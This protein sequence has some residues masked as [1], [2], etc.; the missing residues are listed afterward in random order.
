[1]SFLAQEIPQNMLNTEFMQLILQRPVVLIFLPNT[2]ELQRFV[3]GGAFTELAQVYELHYILPAADAEKMRASVPH[4]ITTANSTELHIDPE[5]FKVWSELFQAA[6]VRYAELSRSFAIRANIDVARKVIKKADFTKW[7]KLR[8]WLRFGKA[9]LKKNKKSQTEESWIIQDGAAANERENFIESQLQ[10]M[11]PLQAIS[12]LFERF[13][14]LLCIIPSSLLDLFCNEVVWSC[15]VENVACL[16][17]QSGWD[18]LSSKGI[19]H[20]SSSFLACWGP[21]SVRHARKIQK[22]P[23]AQT[24]SIGAPHYEFLHSSS[25][26]E[27]KNFRL[28]L[29]VKSDEKLILF[30]GSFRQFD[31]TGI[32][33]CLDKAISKGE[34]GQVKIIYRPHPWR[35]ARQHEDN[36]F[37][38]EWQHIIFDPD[39]RER[40]EREQMEAGYIKR[41]VP[42]FD[43]IYLARILSAVDAVISPMSTLLI[44]SLIMNKPTMAIAF[45][46]GKHSHNPSVTSQMTHFVEAKNSGAFI[47]CDNANELINNCA[48]ILKPFAFRTERCVER[49]IH[50]IVTREP[51]TY[52]SRLNHYCSEK[53]EPHA[54]KLRAIRTNQK[55]GTI[56][57]AYSA[58]LIAREYCKLSLDEPVIPGYWMHG[59]I[60]AYHNIHPALIALH[61]KPGQH[62]GYDFAAQ[63]EDEKENVPQWVS[64]LDQ[65]EF[66]IAEGYKQVK[67]IGLPIVYL[68]RPKVRRIP[69]SLL[70]MP[71]HSHKNHGPDDRLAELYAKMIA[72]LKSN[73]EHIWVGLNEDDIAKKQW[74]ESFR[75]QGINVFSTVDQANPNTLVRLNYLLSSFEYV[76]SNGFGSHIAYAAYCGAKVSIYG[77]YAEFPRER[78]KSTHAVKMFPQLLDD[79]YFLCTEAALQQHYPFLFVE[80]DK[81]KNLSEWGAEQVGENCRLNP[82]ALAD[83]F[84][85][86][87]KSAAKECLLTYDK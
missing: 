78:M 24:T 51:G 16:I 22:I 13:N 23:H 38:H 79:A 55:R 12:D 67:A 57:H 42:M 7:L 14:P 58:H 40:Y 39:M 63:I 65:A 25:D 45:N 53:I 10:K 33:L 81:G 76:S 2:N 29:G 37:K 34:L 11:Q 18:N 31:E 60:P 82:D 73:F 35:A 87:A 20:K 15:D 64:R 28:K 74:I 50:D 80:P 66:L 56:S 43:M 48:L 44:E 41:N 59:W 77:P 21:Q 26:D 46:D 6:C 19:L 32:L 52:A 1:M 69:G 47:W 84:Q 9:V 85:W 17:L 70:I 68:Q 30:G 49:L 72:E 8:N 83:L 4:I 54:R 71:P 3:I 86:T 62:V 27:I 5:R 36:F 75:N 61:K